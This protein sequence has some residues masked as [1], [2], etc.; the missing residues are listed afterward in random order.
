[1]VE[2]DRREHL[3]ETTTVTPLIRFFKGPALLELGYNLNDSKPLLNFTY[4]F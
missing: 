4:R 3:E 2:I 1:M